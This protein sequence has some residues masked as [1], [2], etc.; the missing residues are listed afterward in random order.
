[1]RFTG[2][3]DLVERL[4][5]AGCVYAE[6]EAALLAAEATDDAQLEQMVRRRI[7]GEPLEQVVGWAELGGLRLAVAP[8]V[9]V[10]RRRSELL[11]REAAAL[12]PTAGRLLDLC[13]GVGAV[14]AVVRAVRPRAEIHLSDVDPDAVACARL[15]VSDGTTHVGDLFAALPHG[16]RFDVIAANAP[17]VPTADIAAM[18]PEARDHECRIALDGGHDGVQVHRRIASRAAE[19]LAP[20]G[21]LLVETARHLARS[22]AAAMA[23]HG[24]APRTVHDDDLDATVVIGS[25][26]PD[27][28]G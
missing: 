28:S 9:F 24:F 22:T 3:M 14:G 19:H 12:T 18:P 11:A 7:A 20:G 16:P 21:H 25:P 6:D 4:R 15:N 2:R 26:V 5:A 23:E 1:M 17:Y 13:C 10:P 27:R 8:G